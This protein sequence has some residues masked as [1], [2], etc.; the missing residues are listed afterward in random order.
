MY[1]CVHPSYATDANTI[2]GQTQEILAQPEKS[3]SGKTCQGYLAN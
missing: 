1:T 3:Y 2:S